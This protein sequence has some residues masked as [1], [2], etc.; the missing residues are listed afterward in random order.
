MTDEPRRLRDDPSAPAL[1]R[2]DLRRVE[3]LA[4]AAFDMSRGLER[5]R[6]EM[7]PAAA[8][9]SALKV[10]LWSGGA[11]VA[12]V[13]AL[14]LWSTRAPQPVEPPRAPTVMSAPAP[15][16]PSPAAP[17]VASDAGVDVRPTVRRAQPTDPDARLRRELAH[18]ARLRSL[19]DRAPAEALRLADEGQRAFRGGMFEE[20]RE[21]IA[22]LS[23]AAL[24]REAAARARARTFL[25][26]HPRGPFATRVRAI[27]DDREGATEVPTSRSGG[28]P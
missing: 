10:A 17:Q 12:L 27:A 21:A 23:L 1:V 4:P 9:T 25:V 5:L 11:T 3:Q 26:R 20:E 14:A 19:G 24:G 13:G 7:A 2:D 6:G 18:L 28:S 16:P 22:V 8:T 15:V